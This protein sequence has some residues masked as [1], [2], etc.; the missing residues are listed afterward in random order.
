[1]P[2]APYADVSAALSDPAFVVPAPAE[3]AMVLFNGTDTFT[4]AASDGSL[5]SAPATVT[6]TVT[7]V[8]GAGDVDLYAKSA[9]AAIVWS[10]P[11]RDRFKIAG[12][13]NPRG[14]RTDLTGATMQISVNGTNL[15]APVMLD[16]RGNAAVVSGSTKIKARLSSASGR[17]SF[18]ISGTDLRAALGLVNTTGAGRKHDQRS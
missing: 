7:P 10:S 17:Y 9:S 3:S 8:I 12:K 5:Q 11:N 16:S 14:A 2:F 6:I 18:A 13:L 15:F 4:I 1:M